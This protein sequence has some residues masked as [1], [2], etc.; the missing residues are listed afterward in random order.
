MPTKTFRASALSVAIS[1]AL[2]SSAPAADTFTVTSLDD[3]GPGSLRSVLQDADGTPDAVIEFDPALFGSPQQI[4]LTSQI[5]LDDAD[6]VVAGPGRDL[7]TIS[8]DDNAFARLL[9][10]TGEKVTLQDLSFAG[11]PGYTHFGNG[12]LLRVTAESVEIQRVDF[13]QG[14]V[15]G[16]NGGCLA[17][18]PVS[19]SDGGAVSVDIA[20]STFDGCEVGSYGGSGGGVFAS[21]DAFSM[22]DRSLSVTST[23][24]TNN[25]VGMGNGAGLSV[26]DVG[27]LL[28]SESEFVDNAA[29]GFSSR[30]GAIHIASGSLELQSRRGLGPSALVEQSTIAANTAYSIGGGI[31]ADDLTLEVLSS[32][33]SDNTAFDEGSGVSLSGG[34]LSVVNSTVSGNSD[35]AAISLG[36]GVATAD[37]R[38]STL[39]ANDGPAVRNDSST[40]H[41]LEHTI[42]SGNSGAQPM[43]L[44]GLFES[45]YSIIG[46]V[47]DESE[48]ADIEGTIRTD[49]PEL[50]PLGENGG[51]TLTH[52]PL[53]EGVAVDAGDPVLDPSPEFDQRGP[54]FP[55]LTPPTISIGSVEPEGPDLSDLAI[56]IERSSPASVPVGAT[57]TWTLAVDNLGPEDL[58]E[59]VTFGVE[60]LPPEVEF[61]GL[62]TP[63]D[64]ACQIDSQEG[65]TCTAALGAGFSGI[66]E[67]SGVAEEPGNVQLMADIGC[68]EADDDCTNNTDTADAL[69]ITP[70]S[71]LTMDF[72]SG[73]AELLVGTIGTWEFQASNLGPSDVSVTE[74]EL[75]LPNNLEATA[76][77]EATGVDCS[78]P[79]A[80][81]GGTVTC[82][83]ASI[84][85][86]E[87]FVLGIEAQAAEPGLAEI[88]GEIACPDADPDCGN[89]TAL[90]DE[91]ELFSESDL[92]LGAEPPA[93]EDIEPGDTVNFIFTASNLGPLDY[94]GDW[95][96]NISVP[97]GGLSITSVESTG[98]GDCAATGAGEGWVCSGNVLMNDAPVAF[99]VGVLVEDEGVSSVTGSLTCP[100]TD[101]DCS[102]ND[103]QA[104]MDATA[105]PQH[106]AV[107]IPAMSRVGAG[108]T[109]LF[110]GVVALLG[111]QRRN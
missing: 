77:S 14:S 25:S 50:E 85:A 83:V 47:D 71:D 102:N 75:E 96:T 90:S 2:W 12:G 103:A 5:T 65:A 20:D 82:S 56:A 22:G 35:P 29:N 18:F 55:R 23:A 41:N 26:E 79:G 104:Q 86:G 15:N 95:E 44:T 84:L 64:G 38:H 21:F 13:R 6:V 59:P 109:V 97:D 106:Q 4:D 63:F 49:D 43:D 7:L 19:N 57:V 107:P 80:D 45:S 10:M 51:P 28:I 54:G 30:G 81:V 73:P 67:L 32:T 105:G 88:E 17:V 69:E 8:L 53:E 74:V 72:Q 58:T 87:S 93:G 89:N 70:V 91:T 46:T 78:L 16:S 24:F 100:P 48:L 39:T 31:F 76:L 42:A 40:P 68:P 9:D 62:D 27:T 11:R 92:A 111:L 101:P 60:N 108:I 3:D 98:G 33:V 34:T 37:I 61:T 66:L 36:P 1:A 52:M 94:S 110:M 99:S